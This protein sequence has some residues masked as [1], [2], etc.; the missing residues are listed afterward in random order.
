MQFKQNL[1]LHTYAL[2]F[3]REASGDIFMTV[4]IKEGGVAY[5][6]E[7]KMRVHDCTVGQYNL[8]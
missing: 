5:Y 6:M 4:I 3:A 8:L 7:I 1:I 2:V